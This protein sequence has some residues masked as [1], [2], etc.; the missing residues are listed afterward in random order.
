MGWIGVIR[1][2]KVSGLSILY[3]KG[4]LKLGVGGDG[5]IRIV[6]CIGGNIGD[7]W[8]R[9]DR[10]GRD[11]PQCL[12][13]G[14]NKFSPPGSKVRSRDYKNQKITDSQCGCS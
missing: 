13:G 7:A 8:A 10:V 12:R 4:Y 3:L 6:N 9:L 2:L 11:S 1:K 14:A 5:A